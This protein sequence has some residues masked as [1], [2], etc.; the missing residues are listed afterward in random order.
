MRTPLLPLLVIAGQTTLA[1]DWSERDLLNASK[2]ILSAD[3]LVRPLDRTSTMPVRIEPVSVPQVRIEP[4][5]QPPQ[6]L[7]ETPRILTPQDLGISP[8][9]IN[10]QVGNNLPAEEL[11][12][13][14]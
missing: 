13:K 14:T 1:A 6:L 11:G 4:V 9:A 7:F 5:P 2:T 10:A 3:T 12:K 8:L